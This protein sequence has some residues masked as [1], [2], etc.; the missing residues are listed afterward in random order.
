M[1][2][3]INSSD[4]KPPTLIHKR[5]LDNNTSSQNHENLFNTN[6]KPDPSSKNIVITKHLC[7]PCPGVYTDILKTIKIICK[8][9]T[10]SPLDP[11]IDQKSYV[12]IKSQALSVSGHLDSTDRRNARISSR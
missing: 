10:H 9:P 8:D 12:K 3:N 6:N 1:S 2:P 4:E 7:N 5:K 11:S